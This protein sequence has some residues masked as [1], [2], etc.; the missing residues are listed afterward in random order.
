M[1][2]VYGELLVPVL[3]DLPAIKSFDLELGGRL[4]DY[5]GIGTI[6]TYKALGNWKVNDFISLRGG[7]NRANRA[8]NVAEG[9]TAPTQSVI[10]FPGADPCLSNT[11]N[12]WGNLATNPNQAQVRALCSAI[13]NNPGSQWNADP[14]SIVGPFSGNFPFEIGIT[15]GNPNLKNET[16]DTITLGG[17]FQ[18]PAESGVF[19]AMTLT[20]DYYSIKI[21]NLIQQADAYTI[22]AQCFNAFG[23]NPTYDINYAP[24]QAIHRAPDTGYRQSVD[25]QFINTGT[26]K[27]A[28]LD[29]AFV[30]N[31]AMSDLGLDDAGSLN[32]NVQGNYLFSFKQ[33]NAPGL[34]F[35][36]DVGTL[37]N[38]GHYRWRTTSN[39]TYLRSTWSVGLRW[40]HLPSIKDATYATNPATTNFQ[41]SSYNNF[42]LYGS[43]SITDTVSLRFGIDNLMDSNPRR[44]GVSPTSGGVGFNTVYYDPIGRRFYGGLRFKM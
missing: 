33:Q 37:A 41:V 2:E 18:S 5:T 1:K 32:V 22:Y 4:S 42:S 19:S 7:Y 23:D 9:Y 39:F 27:T 17:V 6:G 38:G 14:S 24:C 26:L 43:W 31:I 29:I 12:S 40:I 44:T 28:G 13:I 20:L 30:W 3:S 25:T 8:P 34:P 15:S 35:E 11:T 16:A 36:S 21:K 10:F